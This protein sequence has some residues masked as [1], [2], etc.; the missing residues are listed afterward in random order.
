MRYYMPADY[1]PAPIRS[2]TRQDKLTML[3][4]V[5]AAL[6]IILAAWTLVNCV[7]ILKDREP[8]IAGQTIPL[9][10]LPDHTWDVTRQISR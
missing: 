8:P 7:V 1:R 10:S 5:L 9:P 2:F 6:G 3:G 4:C